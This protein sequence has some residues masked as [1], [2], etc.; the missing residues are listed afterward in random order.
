MKGGKQ[1]SNPEAET[2][3]KDEVRTDIMEEDGL[4]CFCLSLKLFKRLSYNY[5]GVKRMILRACRVE[6]VR[7]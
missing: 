7:V 4:V 6:Y 1:P 5:A 2:Q 3:I